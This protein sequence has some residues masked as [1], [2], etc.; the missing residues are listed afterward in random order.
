MKS[1]FVSGLLLLCWQVHANEVKL[2]KCKIEA[3]VETPITFFISDSVIKGYEVVDIEGHIQRWLDFSNQA[4]QNSCIPLTRT[5]DKIIFTPEI[6]GEESEELSVVHAFLEYYYPQEIEALNNAK[7]KFYGLIY[8]TNLSKFTSEWCGE[9]NASVYAKFFTIGLTC[10]DHVLEH[11]LG[12]LAWA[13]HDMDTLSTQ[14]DGMPFDLSNQLPLSVK[15]KVKKYSYGYICGGKGTIM[16]Y[17]DQTHP[18]YSSPTISYGSI[19][20]GNAH[21]A[22]NARVLREYALSLVGE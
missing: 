5:L 16:A 8:K 3:V 13:S 1:I 2:P 10:K 19:V 12:H 15:H 22:D 7:A 14:T 6:L 9:T 4:L 11:E 20:C 18:F 17:A 21:Y